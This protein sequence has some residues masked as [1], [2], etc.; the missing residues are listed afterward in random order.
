MIYRAQAGGRDLLVKIAKD[1]TSNPLLEV[2]AAR[3]KKMRATDKMKGIWRFLPE[4]VDSFVIPGPDKRQ[5][6][7]TVTDFNPSMLSLTDIR[8][9]FPDG[10]VPQHAAW[11][12]R[13]VVAQTCA[14][15][16]AGLVHASIV[17][18]HV[19]VDPLKHEPVHI[20]WL[21]SVEKTRLTMILD[22]WK[23]WYPPE[24]F[25]KKVPTHQTDIFMAGMTCIWLF[26]GNTSIISMPSTIPSG[27]TECIKR[28]VE[29]DPSRRPKDGLK[30]L[31]DLTTAIRSA[32]G[33]SY[34]PLLMP[35]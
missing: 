22:R 23:D 8:N 21:H 34:Q 25:E 35:I 29:K 10:L 31:D 7:A 32:W 14:A 28:C 12:T 17:P 13:R 20:G 27:I 9:A 26:S 16:M 2:E 5:Y 6:R 1:P 11:I 15:Q 18:D 33:R 19:L 3:L 30:V 24:I 4:V